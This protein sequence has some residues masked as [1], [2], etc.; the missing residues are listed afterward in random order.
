VRSVEGDMGDIYFEVL[1]WIGL[2]CIKV[3][4]ERISLDGER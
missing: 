3:Q 1:V 4:C 2:A